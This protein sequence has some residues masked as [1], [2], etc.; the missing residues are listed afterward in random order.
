MHLA[1]S[2][3]RCV[4]P[5]LIQRIERLVTQIFFNALPFHG[6]NEFQIMRH[7]MN[8]KRPNQLQS[9]KMGDKAWHLIQSCWE[10]IPSK[11]PKMKKIVEVLTLPA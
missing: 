4:S 8:G 2:I 10:S 3:M 7:I 9:P 6:S 1:V 11:R 5:S